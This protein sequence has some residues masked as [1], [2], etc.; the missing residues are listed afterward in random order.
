MSRAHD[1][2]S[3][4]VKDRGRSC[5]CRLNP[6]A[7][8]VW[9]LGGEELC[10]L[11]LGSVISSSRSKNIR[12]LSQKTKFLTTYGCVF[13]SIQTK[14]AIVSEA[15]CGRGARE[16]SGLLWWLVASGSDK[17]AEKGPLAARKPFTSRSNPSSD[18]STACS[19]QTTRH[20]CERI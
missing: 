20:E 11:A 1:R 2:L 18:T 15:N 13:V 19:Q 6:T 16:R 7:A 12:Q 4:C 5:G 8:K 10:E 3:M 14:F 17:M 9:F